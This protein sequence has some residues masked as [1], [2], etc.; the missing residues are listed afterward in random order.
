MKWYD[1]YLNVTALGS[2]LAY[3][4][5]VSPGVLQSY[6]EEPW[7]WG[8]EWLELALANSLDPQTGKALQSKTTAP[9][10]TPGTGSA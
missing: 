8:D 2:H 4:E 10:P 5:L 6:Y 1:D 3:V 9:A 7:K